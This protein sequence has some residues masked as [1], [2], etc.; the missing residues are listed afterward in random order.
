MD[1]A[2]WSSLVHKSDSRSSIC[3]WTSCISTGKVQLET[4]GV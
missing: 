4:F 1:F 3:Y 2:P